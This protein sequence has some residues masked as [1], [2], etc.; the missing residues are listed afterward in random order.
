MGDFNISTI[1][2]SEPTNLC[3]TEAG[4]NSDR[5][6]P[7]QHVPQPPPT[8]SADD[9]Q[10]RE[11]SSS[12]GSCY[13]RWRG[14]PIY[15][16]NGEVLGWALFSI[17]SQVQFIGAG[18]FLSTA[19]LR[20]AKEA[21]GCATVPPPGSNTVPS[22][23]AR[24]YGIRPSSLLTTYTIVVGILSASCLPLMGAL[25]DYTSHRRL[26][27]RGLAI[28]YCILLFPQ[29]FIGES[30]WFAVAILQIVIAFIGWAQTMITYAYL[31]ELTDSEERLNGYTQ[32][33]TVLSYGSMVI[34]L[35]VVIG[36]ASIA[37]MGSNDIFT[38]RLGQSISCAICCVT[39]FLAWGLL[40]Q[41]RPALR[42]LPT[43]RSLWSAGFVQVFQT[44]LHINRSYSALKWFLISVCL[45]DAS[46]NALATVAIT[47]F[48]TRLAFTSQENGIAIV[49]MLTGSIPG[50]YAAG[51]TTR[52][53]NP[54]ISAIA[55][56]F[57]LAVTTIVAAIILKQPGQQLQTFI[58]AVVWGV[59]TGWR[60][61]TDRLLVS[62]IIPSGQ[63]AELM[64]VYLFAGQ[65]LTWLPPL[66][67]TV[68]NEQGIDERV[69][70]GT[71]SIYFVLGIVALL[72][73][74]NYQKA[75]EVAGR[76]ELLQQNNVD[77]DEAASNTAETHANND[78]QSSHILDEQAV[79]L[80]EE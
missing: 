28:V 57:V 36:A 79:S 1:V 30:T 13:P 9:C 52:R 74:G 38:A 73:M 23:D 33:F 31:P 16:G 39:L 54:I 69:G 78:S 50:A 59:G 48:T 29:I 8:S 34:Y 58:L 72:C 25:V 55:A 68:I 46:I 64:G 56:T 66:I 65:V 63:D 22:C 35:V 44:S 11:Y 71:L 51:W 21:A 12:P 42:E 40:L 15:H 20:L 53:F 62:T 32:S 61:T 37:G 43:D 2:L 14:K 5:N 45:V 17:G 18:A 10:E 49:L 7:Q 19:L 6:K 41:K 80:C 67:F 70:V 75:V 26:I 76:S 27:G 4:L 77:S 3:R 24:V 47:Y 60:W